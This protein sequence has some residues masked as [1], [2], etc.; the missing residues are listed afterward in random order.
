[1]SHLLPDTQTTVPFMIQFFTK[2]EWYY[3][4]W[5]CWGVSS[6]LNLQNWIAIESPSS[7]VLFQDVVDCGE[8]SYLNFNVPKMLQS[9]A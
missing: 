7:L 9:N 8:K 1:M 2:S 3:Y 4:K 5:Y 6:F